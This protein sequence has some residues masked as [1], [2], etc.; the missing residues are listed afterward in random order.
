VKFFIFTLLVTIGICPVL[1]AQDSQTEPEESSQPS[2]S[3]KMRSLLDAIDTQDE[4]LD[5]A[6]K[7]QQKGQFGLARAILKHGIELAKEAGESADEINDELYY[8]LPLLQAKELLVYGY[9]DQA[10]TILIKLEERF[11]DDARRV[12]EIEGL[13]RAVPNS[14]RLAAARE[15]NEDLVTANVRK[16]MSD[17]Y[18][19]HGNFPPAY[20]DLNELIPPGDPVLENFEIILFKSYP[21]AYL[22]VL[23]NLYDKDSF[24]RIEA[25]GLLK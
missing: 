16:R 24:I 3:P 9:P 23:R 2:Y 19:E 12:G 13:L 8:A 20:R 18:S 4:A 6:R 22:I 10:E 1:H 17:Y 7:Y 21:N 14:R 11:S 25:T 5:E 15:S